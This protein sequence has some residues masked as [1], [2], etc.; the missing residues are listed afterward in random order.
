MAV[1]ITSP[2][3]AVVA[4]GSFT[5]SW[6]HDYPQ[7]R[8]EVLYRKKG[9]VN[10]STFGQVSGTATSINVDCSVFPDFVEYQYRVIV[11]SEYADTTETTYSG[12]DASAAYAVVVVPASQVGKMK[13]KYGSG[14]IE[15]PLYST[16]QSGSEKISMKASSTS[17]PSTNMLTDAQSQQ[18][19]SQ[20]RA[21]DGSGNRPIPHQAT[22]SDLTNPGQP[23]Y[24]YMVERSTYY[25]YYYLPAYYK[26]TAPVYTE[27]YRY[28]APYYRYVPPYYAYTAPVYSEYYNYIPAYYNYKYQSYYIYGYVST[29]RYYETYSYSGS[30][31]VPSTGYTIRY[32]RNVCPKYKKLFITSFYYVTASD[33]DGKQWLLAKLAM[34]YYSYEYSYSVKLTQYRSDRSYFG[35][36]YVAE[37]VYLNGYNMILNRYYN[38][39][40]FN[41]YNRISYEITYAEISKTNN[42][43]V[44]YEATPAG[45][46]A[47]LDGYCYIK[48]ITSK[49]YDDWK[50]YKPTYSYILTPAKYYYNTALVTP[51]Y[52]AYTAPVYQYTAPTYNYYSYVTVPPYYQYNAE[53]ITNP[54]HYIYKD[55]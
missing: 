30:F 9:D 28:V 34:Y 55:L 29:Y 52:Y 16:V 50:S 39:N 43:Y 3:S 26:Y 4:R 19:G 46:R 48:W 14:M 33:D 32:V 8:Y 45:D 42:I 25:T 1:T 17:Q 6:T 38:S 40:Y 44:Y 5:L 10:W 49:R 54:V 2:Q 12:S 21:A 36:Y 20:I 53:I 35:N 18:F 7:A 11:Y 37:Y 27:Y 31:Y 23:A 22:A 41:E 13:A 47:V 24:H 51:A 15:V